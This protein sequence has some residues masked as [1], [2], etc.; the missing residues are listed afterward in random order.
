MASGPSTCLGMVARAGTDGLYS[1]SDKIYEVCRKIR[2]FLDKDTG[3]YT[4][5]EIDG[6]K[7]WIFGIVIGVI[8]S[9]IVAMN[10]FSITTVMFITSFLRFAKIIIDALFF[11][12]NFWG[13]DF[14]STVKPGSVWYWLSKC[15]DVVWFVKQLLQFLFSLSTSWLGSWWSKNWGNM[16]Q[17]AAF[18]SG[19]LQFNSLIQVLLKYYPTK[20]GA[21][22][23]A[24]H[25]SFQTKWARVFVLFYLIGYHAFYFATSTIAVAGETIPHG[26]YAMLNVVHLVNLGCGTRSKKVDFLM[27]RFAAVA[28]T[29]V[30]Q[31]YAAVKPDMLTSETLTKALVGPTE[32]LYLFKSGQPKTYCGAAMD[33]LHG[34]GVNGIRSGFTH[35]MY[36]TFPFERLIH[37]VVSSKAFQYDPYPWRNVANVEYLLEW[38]VVTTQGTSYEAFKH[39]AVC[40]SEKQLI[41][42]PGCWRGNTEVPLFESGDKRGDS[43]CHLASLGIR[44]RQTKDGTKYASL[45]Q[46]LTT[47]DLSWYSRW[48]FI[49]HHCSV[50]GLSY[51]RLFLDLCCLARYISD[52]Y[53]GEGVYKR[54]YRGLSPLDLLDKDALAIVDLMKDDT[55]KDHAIGWINALVA[56]EWR[57]RSDSYIYYYQRTLQKSNLVGLLLDM[58]TKVVQDCLTLVV[59][60]GYQLVCR[61]S[62]ICLYYSDDSHHLVS[63]DI[64]LWS[65][66][67]AGLLVRTKDEVKVSP[68]LLCLKAGCFK[69]PCE[70]SD[71]NKFTLLSIK[72]TLLVPA[73]HLL[74]LIPNSRYLCRRTANEVARSTGRV[75]GKV[76]EWIWA[77]RDDPS[78]DPLISTHTHTQMRTFSNRM[79]VFR[80]CTKRGYRIINVNATSITPQLAP[81]QG[82]RS[83]TLPS[84][85][86][87]YIDACRTFRELDDVLSGV[88]H[89]GKQAHAYTTRTLVRPS[90]Q[91]LSEWVCREW[92]RQG[93]IPLKVSSRVISL[94]KK[95]KRE[96]LMEALR[97]VAP[98]TLLQLTT[99]KTR[100]VTREI[101]HSTSS[102]RG[103]RRGWRVAFI[104]NAST[105][106]P[107]FRSGHH[108]MPQ[109]WLMEGVDRIDRTPPSR[110]VPLRP[111]RVGDSRS[112][113]GSGSSTLRGPTTYQ[114]FWSGPA[115]HAQQMHTYLTR[116]CRDY[117]QQGR[118]HSCSIVES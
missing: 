2:L 71:Q 112:S 17:A 30:F 89:D 45:V 106:L 27:G 66:D 69:H 78:D 10:L 39:I 84:I 47:V 8:L 29:G 82:R 117:T 116:L 92:C 50:G 93:W 21:D 74:G 19:S 58:G 23:K 108:I 13:D 34:I 61:G 22:G 95:M 70:P 41:P 101:S 114:A 105:R 38:N 97:R 80:Y 104:L 81:L 96:R 40:S 115:Q 33:F 12:K 49:T 67:I 11:T 60:G 3:V 1:C 48:D 35:T 52:L 51:V 25:S 88:E 18:V 63:K 75:L 46:S 20:Y 100:P 31:D 26:V 102:T 56:S 32:N 62:I 5:D 90:V 53:K 28:D 43:L 76:W 83:T 103:P 110:N 73:C 72:N 87:T 79:Y 64:A 6:W 4:W 42:N 37:K 98:T 68:F 86:N 85:L 65:D 7:R 57:L 24:R 54:S 118:I 36:K 113:G 44:E 99:T 107:T 77:S 91:Q 14:T 15:L 109:G 94:L 16:D 55:T 111:H 9:G 59:G